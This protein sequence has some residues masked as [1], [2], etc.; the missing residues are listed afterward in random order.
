MA[1]CCEPCCLD[2]SVLAFCL[3]AAATLVASRVDFFSYSILIPHPAVGQVF[4]TIL[5]WQGTLLSMESLTDRTWMFGSG[6]GR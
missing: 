1:L 5:L 3:E 6:N 2:D 4:F